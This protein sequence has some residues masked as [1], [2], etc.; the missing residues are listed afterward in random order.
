VITGYDE[1]KKSLGSGMVEFLDNFDLEYASV[2]EI[3]FVLR[4]LSYGKENNS[5][6]YYR[7]IN[8]FPEKLRLLSNYVERSPTIFSLRTRR[9]SRDLQSDLSKSVDQLQK[10]N[11]LQK[12]DKCV[13]LVG[14][15]I[16]APS[17]IPVVGKLL[18]KIVDKANKIHKKEI[19]DLLNLISKYKITDVETLLTAAYFSQ[20]SLKNQKLTLL[21]NT[22][23]NPVVAVDDFD[24]TMDDFNIAQISSS[25]TVVQD[26]LQNL[27]SLI[28]STMINATPNN[29][30]NSI[31]NFA[32]NNENVSI[33]TTNY[34]ICM[35]EAISENKI[36][37]GLDFSV[38][39]P[40]NEVDKKNLIELIKMHG[41]INW[42][43]CDSCQR[44]HKVDFEVIRN[45]RN[46]NQT[47]PIVGVCQNPS[48]Q[49]IQT[50]LIVPPLLYKFILFPNLIEI[51]NRAREL[52]FKA[53]YI[54][55]SGYSFSEA[56]TYISK[57]VSQSMNENPNQVLIVNDI[58]QD[59]LDRI[60][61]FFK[62]SVID[63]TDSRFIP[64]LGD[65][66]K[67]VPEIVNK[68]KGESETNKGTTKKS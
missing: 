42:H 63:L 58:S 49:S 65:C 44:L 55:V 3:D 64:V 34:D 1:F 19:D 23:I 31:A 28:T 12:D 21:L 51:W 29:A 6:Y 11:V 9:L 16:S 46:N 53:K 5:E 7:Y 35:D 26:T 36:E 4:R 56:D 47:Y 62:K 48:C 17:N 37:Y 30:H 57:I 33:V 45:I 18:E 15:G 13:F 14:A 38:Y 8:E 68:L 40:E 10:I 24:E 54:V 20:Y 32:L 41:S 43:Y 2:S 27:F 59:G 66:V 52:V 60:R 61:R 39:P 50:P 67:A 22:F 25:I